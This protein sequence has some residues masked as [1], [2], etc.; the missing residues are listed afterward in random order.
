MKNQLENANAVVGLLM[1]RAG[2]FSGEL[3]SL[4]S[5][6]AVSVRET[7][8]YISKEISGAG[9]TINLVEASTDKKEGVTTFNGNKFP[10]NVAKLIDAIELRVGKGNP[11]NL[12]AIKFNQ[13]EP[14][15]LM[16]AHLIIEQN[17]RKLLEKKVS[18]FIADGTE[19]NAEDRFV[20]LSLPLILRDVEDFDIKLK[21][22]TGSSVPSAENV[23]ETEI[24]KVSFRAYE[25]GR[26][27]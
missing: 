7:T 19:I 5:Q 20:P 12:G 22:P 4:I 14:A 27:S 9:G 15:Q 1:D 2:D 13:A 10:Q 3:S 23:A 8:D 18:D 17:G 25:T 24:V 21:F 26:K 6:G 16:N 11:N